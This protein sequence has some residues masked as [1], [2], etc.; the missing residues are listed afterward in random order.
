MN[1]LLAP[2]LL[3]SVLILNDLFLQIWKEG[4]VAI[5]ILALLHTYS[6]LLESMLK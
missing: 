3:W 5:S 2:L 4:S 1:R 6:A